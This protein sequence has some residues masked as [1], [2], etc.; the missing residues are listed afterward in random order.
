MN[1]VHANFR[2]TCVF[3]CLALGGCARERVHTPPA[4]PVPAPAAVSVPVPAL[5]AAAP[6][7]IDDA[8]LLAVNAAR[9]R[10][11]RCG[12]AAMPAVAAL[13]LSPA[14]TIAATR[15]AQDQAARG[16][17]GHQGSDG[18]RVSDRV[19]RTGY[20]WRAVG[21]NVYTASWSATAAEAV[22]SWLTS[23]G[24]CRNIMA[25]HF[26]ELGAGF[27]DAGKSRYWTQVFAAPRAN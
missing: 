13:R 25:G 11:R 21:E 18:S 3:F 26:T 1:T 19:N 22:A 8:M 17:I 4:T 14:L 12:D 24:H 16:E 20:V 7:I 6:P 2:T 15:H 23:P 27:V 5:P 9:A 10:A